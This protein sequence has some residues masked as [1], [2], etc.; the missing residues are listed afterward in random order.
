LAFTSSL[1]E[2]Q[3]AHSEFVAGKDLTEELAGRSTPVLC[4][5]R[6]VLF[7]QG[8]ESLGVYVLSKGSATL[9]MQSPSG[10]VVL[11]LKAG[12]G[13]VLGLHAVMAHKPYSLTA[14]ARRG[15]KVGFLAREEL[16]AM[17]SKQSIFSLQVLQVL[18][19]QVQAARQAI[20]DT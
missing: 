9:T 8:D 2:V 16:T 5:S 7:R 20:L 19:D 1:Q 4:S 13:S 6:R 11:R 3:V 12:P 15:A 18:A 17:K 14:V 10:E